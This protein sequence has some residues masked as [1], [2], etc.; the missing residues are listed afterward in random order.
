[1]KAMLMQSTRR[2]TRKFSTQLQVE[3][4]EDEVGG[5]GEAVIVLVSADEAL[6]HAKPT[7]NLQDRLNK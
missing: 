3:T 5:E 7:R 6:A 1:M 4:S 2:L